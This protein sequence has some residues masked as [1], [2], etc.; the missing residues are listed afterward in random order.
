MAHGSY[1]TIIKPSKRDML[2][3]K[4]DT[5]EN[6]SLLSDNMNLKNPSLG[7]QKHTLDSVFVNLRPRIEL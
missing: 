6:G 3:I 7:L 4:N 1:A 2:V 5:P